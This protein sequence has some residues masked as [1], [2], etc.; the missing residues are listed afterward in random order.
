MKILSLLLSTF[1][2]LSANLYAT[3]SIPLFSSL[4]PKSRMPFVYGGQDISRTI[5]AN[6]NVAL[7]SEETI[8]V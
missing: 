6:A 5:M 8:T 3:T 4:M 1:L 7:V 2:L